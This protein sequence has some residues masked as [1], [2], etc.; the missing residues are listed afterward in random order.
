VTV[1][2]FEDFEV[3]QRMAIGPRHVEREEIIAFASQ[4]DPQ[5][6]HLDDEAAKA[7]IFGALSASGWHTCAMMMR[8]ICDA[9][10]SKA[11]VLGSPGVDY[12]KWKKPVFVGDVLSGEFVITGA[13]VSESRKGIGIL[14]YT[15]SVHDQHATPKAEFAGPVFIRTRS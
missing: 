12:I 14:N 3:G 5:A 13:R 7:G 2:F 11:A 9:A 15:C 1:L 4:Y 6:F 8:M 10:I